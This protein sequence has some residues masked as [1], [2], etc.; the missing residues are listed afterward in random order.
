M[1]IR[2]SVGIRPKVYFVEASDGCRVHVPLC[3]RDHRPLDSALA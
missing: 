1:R 3:G 2:N